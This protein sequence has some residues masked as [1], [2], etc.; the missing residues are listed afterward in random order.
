VTTPRAANLTEVATTRRF[1][2]SPPEW[3]TTAIAAVLSTGAYLVHGHPYLARG[4]VGDL[5]GFVVLGAVGLAA[6]AR[7]KHEAA[8]CLALIGLVV[9]AGPQWPLALA[10]QAWWALFFLGL[11][12]YIAIRRRSCD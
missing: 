10:E 9:L 5:L 11:A 12:I 1:A 3:A 2:L 6:H 4:V 7:V 8:L